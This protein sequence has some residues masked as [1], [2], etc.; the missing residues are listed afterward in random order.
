[1]EN[2]IIC[3]S[4]EQEKTLLQELL[5]K[6]RIKFQTVREEEVILTDEEIADIETGRRDIADGHFESSEQVR[7]MMKECLK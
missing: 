6:M 4:S 1:M 2:I 7:A 5:L 3:P